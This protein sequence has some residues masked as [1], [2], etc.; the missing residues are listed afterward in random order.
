M[1][2]AHLHIG[3]KGRSLEDIL[4]RNTSRLVRVDEGA[5]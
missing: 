4:R 2:D 5:G 3:H 1:V